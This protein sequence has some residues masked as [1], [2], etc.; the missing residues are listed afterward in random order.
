[1]LGFSLCACMHLLVF[2]LC[3]VFRG[4]LVMEMLRVL[5]FV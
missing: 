4:N 2:F 3:V 1:M 5:G